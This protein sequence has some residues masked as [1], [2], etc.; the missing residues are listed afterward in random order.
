MP[1]TGNEHQKKHHNTLSHPTTGRQKPPPD[2]YK[3]Q[4]QAKS[5]SRI[6]KNSQIARRFSTSPFHQNAAAASLPMK[7]AAGKPPCAPSAS[8][9]PC[10]RKEE[11]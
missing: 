3:T 10:R 2:I 5:N 8:V 6:V 9:A 11:K 7:A 1:R 4:G